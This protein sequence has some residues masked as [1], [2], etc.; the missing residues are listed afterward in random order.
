MDSEYFDLTDSA[1]AIQVLKLTPTHHQFQLQ[2]LTEGATSNVTGL[3]NSSIDTKTKIQTN[4]LN[5]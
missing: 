5:A 4:G 1:F 3:I 2:S